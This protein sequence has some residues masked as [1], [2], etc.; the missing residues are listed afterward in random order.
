M[1]EPLTKIGTIL[2]G[3]GNQ[4]HPQLRPISQ[5]EKHPLGVTPEKLR[6][7]TNGAQRTELGLLA[8]VSTVETQLVDGPIVPKRQK[9]PALFEPGR[10][11]FGDAIT[12]KLAE[13]RRHLDRA[14]MPRPEPLEPV[15]ESLDAL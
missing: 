15:R 9:L 5:D 6:T 8:E 10:A 7:T 3:E 13:E 11:T 1:I 2:D 12:R 4:V 14:R